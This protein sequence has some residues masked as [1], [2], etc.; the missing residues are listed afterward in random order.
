MRA[1]RRRVKDRYQAR[2]AVLVA[3]ALNLV[4]PA[5]LT[6]GPIWVLLVIIALFLLPLVAMTPTRTRDLH[7]MRALTI[8]LVAVLNFFNVASVVLLIDDLLNVHAPGHVNLNAQELL[9]SGAAIWL[10]NIII[11]ALWF[12]ELD[13]DGPFD[14]DR[15]PSACETP[16][17]DFLFPQMSMDPNRI[18]G[19]P[20]HWRPM[21]LDYLYLSFTNALAVSPT[22]VMPITRTAKMLMLGESLISFVTVALILARSVNILS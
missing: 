2:V 9:S 7:V 3:L 6:L 11:F 5:K 10:T 18:K 17:I 21:F 13:G 12:W 4:L 22:D 15:F 14:R 20:R 16:S 19:L 8:G 1:N